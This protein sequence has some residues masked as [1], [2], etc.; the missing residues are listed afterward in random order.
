MYAYDV[1]LL[2][3]NTCN[4]YEITILLLLLLLHSM[5]YYS[6]LKFQRETINILGETEII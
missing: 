3:T 2:L 6:G 4:M 1:D 5:A